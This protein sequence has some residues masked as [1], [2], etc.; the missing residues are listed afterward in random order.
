MEKRLTT[1][2]NSIWERLNKI[3]AMAVAGVQYEKDHDKLHADMAE[4]EGK[5]TDE[6]AEAQRQLSEQMVAHSKMMVQAI[7]TMQ[8][9]IEEFINK[10][11]DVNVDVPKIEIPAPAQVDKI[12]KVKRGQ[13]GLIDEIHEREA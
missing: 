8:K 6:L 13:N 7:T 5:R 4:R 1:E 3:E 2:I 10:K 9:T 12:Y 11:I